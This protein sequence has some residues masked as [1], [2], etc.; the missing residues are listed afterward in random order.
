MG[1]M[2]GSQE[3]CRVL[4]RGVARLRPGTICLVLLTLYLGSYIF[5]SRVTS[6]S[7]H[8]KQ[9][10]APTLEVKALGPRTV[11]MFVPKTR[12][13]LVGDTSFFIRR[14]TELGM[15][16]VYQP[17]LCIDAKVFGR[18]HVEWYD[19]HHSTTHIHVY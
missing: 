6:R 4:G 10:Y 14:L 17:L 3:A 1:A 15:F 18:V 13:G 2:H 9:T 11:F 5:F 7:W 8:F 12:G 19:Q 16:W